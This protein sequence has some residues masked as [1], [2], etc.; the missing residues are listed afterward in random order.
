MRKTNKKKITADKIIAIPSRLVVT[1]TVP[2]LIKE[3]DFFN[4]MAKLKS[5]SSSMISKEFGFD[6]RVLGA[7]LCYLRKEGFVKKVDVV[8]D[9][10]QLSELSNCFLVN[11]SKYDL[12]V[13]ARLLEGNVPASTGE[14][15]AFALSNGRPANWNNVSGSWKTSMESGAISK[16]FSEG[17]MSRG[18]YLR[19]NLYLAL[20]PILNKSINLLDI[21]GSLG[22]YAGHFTERFRKLSCV[23]FDLPKVIERAKENIL[24]MK[25]PRVGVLAGDMFSEGFPTGFDAHFYSNVVHDWA[26]DQIN[27]LFKK[28]WESLAK[29]GV[30]IVHDMHLDNSKIKPEFVVDHSL[31]L[32]I[33]TE[34]RCY[35]YEEIAS[36]MKLAGFKKILIKKTVAG[37]SVI[38]GYKNK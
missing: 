30:I 15:I 32:S 16:T 14:S 28:S 3:F 5:A 37:Y 10:Y 12:S 20:K 4:R 23:I 26:S 9:K 35:S 8:N 19:D 34:G 17:M 7:L 29:N 18:K 27:I 25:Y 36:F 24:A 13:Y 31:Y 21:G 33:Y 1:H 22:D 2:T 6:A 38:V 11:K